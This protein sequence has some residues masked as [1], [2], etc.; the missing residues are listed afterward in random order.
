MTL[1]A[2]GGGPAVVYVIV[3]VVI[4]AT[5]DTDMMPHGQNGNYSRAGLTAS[6]EPQRGWEQ[7]VAHKRCIPKWRDLWPA[8]Q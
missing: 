2:S 5:V 4:N 8:L 1:R 6:L 7:C 3:I